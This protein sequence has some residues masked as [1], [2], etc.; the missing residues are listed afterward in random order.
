MNNRDIGIV[1]V[2]GGVF[3]VL[4]AYSDKIFGSLAKKAGGQLPA[5]PEAE[6]HHIEPMTLAESLI[7]SYQDV[8][9]DY[10]I[11]RNMEPALITAMIEVLSQGRSKLITKTAD[12]REAYG[13]MQLTKERSRLGGAV[14]DIALLFTKIE[15]LLEPNFNIYI[16]VSVM[17]E[18]I[19]KY[20]NAL[21]ALAWYDAEGPFVTSFTTG[22]E[23]WYFITQV[24]GRV[25]RYRLLWKNYF[26][27][28]DKRFHIYDEVTN[29]LVRMPVE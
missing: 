18:G 8:I 19:K 2:A 14:S 20:G 12:G 16:G 24:C 4:L 23:N 27:D 9:A 1:A 5:S 25:P 29:Y 26:E 3:A 17:Q 6:P 15:K 13:L 10:T 11:V 28:Y 22:W 7:M 21:D